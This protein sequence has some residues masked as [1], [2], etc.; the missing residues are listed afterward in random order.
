MI[1]GRDMA[2][3]PDNL[4]LV[5]RWCNEVSSSIARQADPDQQAIRGLTFHI[6]TPEPQTMERYL[7]AMYAIGE[8]ARLTLHYREKEEV[9]GDGLEVVVVLVQDLPGLAMWMLSFVSFFQGS[10]TIQSVSSE[11]NE[12]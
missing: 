5:T 3:A 6:S 2:E 9:L 8:I 7:P 11:F 4:V 12:A 1:S 10:S